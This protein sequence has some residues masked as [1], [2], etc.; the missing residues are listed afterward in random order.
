[1]CQSFFRF[2]LA[3]LFLFFLVP[4]MSVSSESFAERFF[5]D[6]R[7]SLLYFAADN[8]SNSDPAP[9]IPSFG[10]S[11]ALKVWG[12][13][14][15]E[16]TEDIYFTNYEFNYNLWYPMA[17]NPENRSA[18]VMGFLT[19]LQLTAAFPLGGKGTSVRVYGG[20]AADFRLV[21]LAVGLNHP[22]DFTGEIESDPQMQTNAINEYFWNE[23]RWLFPVAGAGIDFPISE[24]FL[25]GF[26]VRC[27][28]P[29]YRLW[30]DNNLPALDGWRF[31]VSVRIT[32]R[33]K[34]TRNTPA[35]IT[36]QDPAERREALAEEISALIRE[37]N[38][39]DADVQIT[40][41]GIMITLSNIQFQSESAILLASEMAKIEEVAIVLKNIRGI[42]L[43]VAG[44]TARTGSLEGQI[45][46]SLERA[47][48]V[49]DYLVLLGAVDPDHIT[50]VGYGGERP[51]SNSTT[52]A[53]MSVNRRVEI[54][55][56]ED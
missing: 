32:P 11:A 55:I 33:S 19:G 4:L 3:A 7:L 28:F 42:K 40:D 50:A 48:A 22:D 24:S 9:I 45:S 43:L 14:R 26:D 39:R 47:Q 13:L 1:M 54:I 12:P 46:L 44:H 21:V 37:H 53:G 38:V 31:G 27:W 18:F 5:W 34:A 36:S 52:P 30:T 15:L 56:L 41:E 49:A 51:I 10:I 16:L 17:C 23:G 6:T 2:K 8:G 29:M 35:S 20:P 25:L